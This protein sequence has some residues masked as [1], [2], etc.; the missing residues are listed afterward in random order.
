MATARPAGSK[1]VFLDDSLTQLDL[2]KDALWTDR[3]F[4]TGPA[5]LP[6]END[7]YGTTTLRARGE[8][9][10]PYAPVHLRARSVDGDLRLDWIRRTR[11]PG[12]GWGE[13]DVPLGEVRER[14]RVRVTDA[15]GT[16]VWE[17][18]TGEP[19]AVVP[20]AVLARIAGG[21]ARVSVAQLS[22]D[23][24]PGPAAVLAI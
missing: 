12:D 22:E 23:V 24:G 21:G 16:L 19:T 15:G 9:L 7:A 11:V 17:S 4:R 5:H 2:P 13:V 14:Y 10:K 18:D 20:G 6:L 3:Y 1:V 8:G